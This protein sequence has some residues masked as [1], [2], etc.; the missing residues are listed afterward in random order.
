MADVEIATQLLS[1]TEQ[2]PTFT[3]LNAT[4]TFY[5]P[6]N[7]AR[8]ILYFKN[9]NG[10]IATITFDITQTVD[11]L[12]LADHTIAVPATTGEVVVGGLPTR[13][14][15][16]SGAQAGKLKMTCSVATGCSVAALAI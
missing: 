14:T 1:K 5:I 8:T 7:T 12:A 11:G 13:M 2:A 6:N 15:E 10:S 4:D 3:T 9:T 16:G